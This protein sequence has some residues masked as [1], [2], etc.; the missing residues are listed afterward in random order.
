MVRRRGLIATLIVVAAACGVVSGTLAYADH[1]TH[2]RSSSRPGSTSLTNK[3]IHPLPPPR[4]PI[5]QL[6]E[7]GPSARSIV[8]GLYSTNSSAGCAANARATAV[9]TA[10]TI[11]LHVKETYEKAQGCNAG[12]HRFIVRVPL[13]D[14]ING[15][16]VTGTG[17]SWPSSDEQYLITSRNGWIV[18]TVPRVVGLSATQAVLLLRAQGFR[19]KTASTSGSTVVAQSPGRGQVPSDSNPPR[20]FFGT[21]NLA[22]D[23]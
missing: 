2:G 4:T 22:T 5:W 17:L 19:G 21:V 14:P 13:H 8:I 16:R 18:S 10:T 7:T 3:P 23:R 20:Q 15:R 1:A 11:L 9:E 6:M 12:E